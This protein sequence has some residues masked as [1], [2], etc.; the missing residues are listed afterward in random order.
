ML[1][2]LFGYS[3]HVVNLHLKLSNQTQK[4]HLNLLFFGDL[5]PPTFLGQGV[6]HYEGSSIFTRWAPGE[7]SLGG[8]T[9]QQP[10]LTTGAKIV[11]G[12]LIGFQKAPVVGGS[13]VKAR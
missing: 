11:C 1:V 12:L 7:A 5:T 10:Q 9:D 6:P 8:S 2:L 13:R 4:H 3:T